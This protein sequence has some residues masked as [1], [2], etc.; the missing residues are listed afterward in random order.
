LARAATGFY[1]HAA[2]GRSLRDVVREKGVEESVLDRALDY[3]A[4]ARARE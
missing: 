3:R 1:G 4:M 2:T